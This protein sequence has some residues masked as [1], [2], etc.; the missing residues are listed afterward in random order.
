MSERRAEFLMP[1]ANSARGKVR[2]ALP[3]TPARGTPPETPGPLSLLPYLPERSS[4]SRVRF[5]AHKP[6]A[7]DRSGPFRR[8]SNEKGKRANAKPACGRVLPP[9]GRPQLHQKFGADKTIIGAF[10]HPVTGSD[11]IRHTGG[12]V[13]TGGHAVLTARVSRRTAVEGKIGFSPRRA[14]DGWRQRQ[15]TGSPFRAPSRAGTAFR[16]SP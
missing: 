2:G 12:S 10:M 9:V 16:S 1:R 13:A 14:R 15:R 4:P 3:R 5:A 11:P 6:R 8:L 7:L